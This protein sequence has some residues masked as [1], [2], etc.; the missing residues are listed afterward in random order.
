MNLIVKAIATTLAIMLGSWLFSGISIDSWL[1]GIGAG[2]LIVLL[3]KFVKPILIFLT[4]PIT[5]ITLGLF[6]LVIN[7]IIIIIADKFI[8]GFFVA[9]FWWALLLSFIVSFINSIAEKQQKKHR[10]VKY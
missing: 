8:D 4:I 1:T 9:S 2:A 6:L 7:A 3:N 5:I 10:R